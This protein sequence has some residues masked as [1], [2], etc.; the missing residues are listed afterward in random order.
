M[1]KIPLT[2]F[3]AVLASTQIACSASS[4]PNVQQYIAQQGW[5]PY[6]TKSTVLPVTDIAPV[7]YM[8]KGNFAPSCG[9]LVQT[10]A[11]PA[12][13]EIQRPEQGT[14]FPQCL[15]I[16]DVAAFDLNKKKY[17]VF[18]YINR[19][20]KEDFYREYFYVYKD[21]TGRYVAD[22]ELNNS[23][24]WP[25]PVPASSNGQNPPRAKDGVRRARGAAL[26]KSVP[27]MK[28]LGR[29]FLLD[30]ARAFAIF[31]DK[32]RE[33]C[34][35]V[36]ETAAAPAIFGHEL[37]SDGDKCSSVLASSKLEKDGKAYYLAMFK[38]ANQNHLA[39]VS[40]SKENVVT[41]E[42]DAAVAVNKMGKLSN[43]KS[44][45]EA[46]LATLK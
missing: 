30:H 2:L 29:D 40:V 31:Q 39:V 28:F 4:A 26:S 32:A 34:A 15:A 16:N 23:D 46:L 18:E 14:G 19:D 17:L 35:F 10:S 8:T 38:G 36:I 12:F 1:K 27:G 5:T 41:P 42:K 22:K 43:I 21:A 20:T 7:M 44:A 3:F 33:K 45:K 9:L 37:F 11:A 13:I 24:V 6:Q 25:E